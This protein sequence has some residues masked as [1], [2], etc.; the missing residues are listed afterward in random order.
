MSSNNFI[1]EEVK[2]QEYFFKLAPTIETEGSTRKFSG[3]AYGGGVITDHSWWD[4]VIFDLSTTKAENKMPVLL[5]HDSREIVGYTE[6]VQVS[7]NIVVSGVISGQETGQ[8]VAA[9]ADE[10][11]PWQMSVRLKPDTISDIGKGDSV[12]VNGK[13]YQGPITVLRDSIIREVSFCALGADRNT[14]ANIF[15]LKEK[16][17]AIDEPTKTVS[18]TVDRDLALQALTDEKNQ[19]KAQVDEMKNTQT[20]LLSE[21]AD[22]KSQLQ[23]T[24]FENKSLTDSLS[25]A[26][27][28]AEEF[29]AKYDELTRSARLTVL[30]SDYQRLG[31]E[32]KADDDAIKAILGADIAA[33]EAFRKVIG[34]I[35]P[36]MAPPPG[37]F[38]AQTQDAQFSADK[39]RVSLAEAASKWG[40][41][42]EVING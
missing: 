7:T 25:M 9:M 32:F 11:F 40:K 16:S 22:L 23:S 27:K 5:E 12:E 20:K 36:V 18:N 24:Q 34:A 28:D 33:F 21:N 2:P 37:M 38:K 8:K 42:Q 6:Q 30:E 41:K 15:S 26:R 17:M 13:K 29:R 14:V 39:P 35:N 1:T 3:V 19:F 10:G 4:R 31:L